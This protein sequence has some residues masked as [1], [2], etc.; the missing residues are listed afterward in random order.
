[1]FAPLLMRFR[2]YDVR[3]GESLSAECRKLVTCPPMRQWGR[4][5]AAKSEVLE[6]EEVV[7]P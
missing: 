6:N 2:T 3:L 1:M 7:W 4:D 5:V